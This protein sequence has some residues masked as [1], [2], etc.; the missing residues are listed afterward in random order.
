MAIDP[1]LVISVIAPIHNIA[2]ILEVF[3]EDVTRAL[4]PNYAFFEIILV[5]DGSTDSTVSVIPLL[6]DRFERVRYLR[7]S[8]RFGSEVAISAGLDSAIGDFTVILSAE[9]DPCERIPELITTARHSGS[10]LSGVAPGQKTRNPF[11]KFAASIF[12]S[13]CQNTLGIELKPDST[14]FRVLSRQVVNAITQIKDRRRYLRLFTAAVGYDIQYFDYQPCHHTG[15]ATR[16]S[17]M[18]EV[19]LAID[20]VVTSS[21]H[22]LRFVSRVGILASIL[23]GMYLAYIAFVYCLKPH[24]AEGWTT[25]S[26][27]ISIMFFFLFLILSVL[28]EYVGRLLE[29]VQDRPLYFIAQEK[30]SSVLLEHQIK[31]NIVHVSTE[32]A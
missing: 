1:N 3:L 11:T 29:E 5:D 30:N 4:E 19:N 6:L 18:D 15:K 20:I 24:V 2:D 27:E 16:A 7:L 21:P 26:L 31:K 14:N 28:C 17:F 8:R 12:R 22:P 25:T 10:I 9:S 23:N 32:H 13:Y